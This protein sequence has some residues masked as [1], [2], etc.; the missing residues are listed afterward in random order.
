MR[1]SI[2]V[3][4]VLVGIMGISQFGYGWDRQ[5]MSIK[6]IETT[7]MSNP[8]PGGV[9][10][11]NDSLSFLSGATQKVDVID[12]AT[13]GSGVTVD[14]VLLKDSEMTGDIN[15]DDVTATGAYTA[16]IDYNY[17][18]STNAILAT[19]NHK[20]I[21]VGADDAYMLFNFSMYNAS[22][23]A[24][25]FVYYKTVVGEADADE[26]D[27]ELI[28]GVESASTATDTLKVDENG[29]TVLAGTLQADNATVLA[30][31]TALNGGLTM[32]GNAFSVADTTGNTVIKG[33]LTTTGNVEIVG[34]LTQ[35]GN[36][37][38]AGNLAYTN[39]ATIQQLG[40]GNLQLT[41]ALFS[42]NGGFNVGGVVAPGDNNMRVEGTS[43]LIGNTTV[44]GTLTSTGVVT[45]VAAPA[46]T[47]TNAPAAET[48]TMTNSPDVNNNADPVWVQITIGGNI[49]VMPAWELND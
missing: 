46:V 12:E 26:E 36:A 44:T 20:N 32:D 9:I 17:P 14:G 11:V 40:A 41:E 22:T 24:Q 13:S 38:F 10:T 37:T 23:S 5:K 19:V 47:V 15:T 4:L 3:M 18:A 29:V 30:G 43:A 35:T 16:T 6:Q 7:Q 39:G 25:N 1:K 8:L 31:T 34:T 2:V 42:I 33:T 49:F 48:N 21:T 45:M 27:G 28:I